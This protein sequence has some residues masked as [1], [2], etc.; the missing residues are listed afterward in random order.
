M[1]PLK[2]QCLL[3][4]EHRSVPPGVGVIAISVAAE[5][6]QEADLSRLV[7]ADEGETVKALDNTVRHRAAEGPLRHGLVLFVEE[8]ADITLA[9][10]GSKNQ[11]VLDLPAT[12]T[13][14][15]PVLYLE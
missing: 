6:L 7:P 4:P 1:L 2:P 13:T 15:E 9:F 3:F 8:L 14:G 10:R 5:F 12:L 11:R